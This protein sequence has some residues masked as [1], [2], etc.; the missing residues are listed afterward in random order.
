VKIREDF[1]PIFGDKNW[2]LHHNSLS[3]TSLLHY[4]NS[5][6]KHHDARKGLL[7]GQW[8]PLDAVCVSISIGKQTNKQTEYRHGE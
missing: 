7:G 2:L 4:G 8:W 5:G 3:H 6:K 1:V